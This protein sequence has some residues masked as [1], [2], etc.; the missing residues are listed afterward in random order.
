MVRHES[1]RVCRKARSQALS[2]S[3]RPPSHRAPR[4]HGV[5]RRYQC[6]VPK[7]ALPM[8][9]HRQTLQL[10][11]GDVVKKRTRAHVES[12]QRRLAKYLENSQVHQRFTKRTAQKPRRQIQR[13]QQGHRHNSI[14]LRRCMPR[15]MSPRLCFS[16][17]PVR[18]RLLCRTQK[19][20]TYVRNIRLGTTRPL[21]LTRHEPSEARGTNEASAPR[22]QEPPRSVP[23][24]TNYPPPA[25]NAVSENI[26]SSP[27]VGTVEQ[28]HRGEPGQADPAAP[29][30]QE[31]RRDVPA[32]PGHSNAR[33]SA[34]ASPSQGQES[35]GVQPSPPTAPHSTVNGDSA[36]RSTTVPNNDDGPIIQLHIERPLTNFQ[37]EYLREQGIMPEE[38]IVNGQRRHVYHIWHRE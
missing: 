25:V 2:S 19:Q 18:A 22:A 26:E 17:A 12:L 20:R 7:A 13:P 28:Q 36:S 16:L 11:L 34:P 10:R 8:L 1:R 38:L 6:L 3:P 23:S 27:Q 33:E 29:T 9:G 5:R 15:T 24:Q 32:H 14:R 35:N 30:G 21:V 31:Q 4:V 37:P